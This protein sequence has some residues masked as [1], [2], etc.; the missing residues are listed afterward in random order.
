MSNLD[1]DPNHEHL[2]A[3]AEAHLRYCSAVHEA[4]L[5]F[6]KELLKDTRLAIKHWHE[7]VDAAEQAYYK[8]VE[9]R[10]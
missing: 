7:K 6:N 9:R 5:E 8:S 10:S 3:V 2:K 4:S 1:G